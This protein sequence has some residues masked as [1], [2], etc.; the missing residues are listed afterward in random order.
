MCTADQT[1]QKQTYTYKK[2]G[3]LDIIADVFFP[4]DTRIKPV[5]VW[6]HGGALI[7]GHRESVPRYVRNGFLEKDCILISIDYRLA[8]ET[9]FPEIIKDIE[10]AF[11]WIR[12]EGPELFNADPDRIAIIGGSAGGYLTLMAG[13]RVQPPPVVLVALWGYGDLIGAWLSKPSSH[14]RHHRVKLTREEAYSQVSGGPVANARDRNGDG[15]AFYQYLRQNGLWPEAVSGWNPHTDAEKFY[16]FMP[17]KNVTP[18]FP[19]VLLVH[20]TE[21]TDVPYEQ[22]IMMV[23]E[24]KKHGVEHRLITVQGAEHGLAGA[25]AERKEE[26]YKQVQAFIL[27]KLFY[28]N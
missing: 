12:R 19:T 26:V 6:I 3:N 13:C 8:P 22:S 21:D 20:G 17:V 9:M 4:D 5:V 11:K 23:E 1:V 15:A 24:F 2:V 28:D 14:P 25:D 10:D 7:N 27:Q 18:E 16:P